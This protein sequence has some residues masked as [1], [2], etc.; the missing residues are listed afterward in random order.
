M[1]WTER[2]H[3]AEFLIWVAKPEKRWIASVAALPRQG[4]LYTAGPGEEVIPGD[5]DTAE[6]AEKAAQRYIIQKRGR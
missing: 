5:F 3:F 2:P 1:E 4:G 6:N